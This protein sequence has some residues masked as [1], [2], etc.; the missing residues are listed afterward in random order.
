MENRQYTRIED[1]YPPRQQWFEVHIN[2]HQEGL[3]IYFG[4]ITRRKQ[5]ETELKESESRFHFFSSATTEGI[6]ILDNGKIADANISLAEMFGYSQD[7]IIGKSVLEFAPSEIHELI[8]EK[9]RSC[10]EGSFEL[11]GL[12]KDGTLFPLEAEGRSLEDRGR[13]VRVVILRNLEEKK[14]AEKGLKESEERFKFLSSVATEGV[15]IRSDDIII[16]AN[17][18]LANMFG[19]SLEELY[20]MPSRKLVTPESLEQ[21]QNQIKYAESS[22]SAGSPDNFVG[23]FEGVGIRKDGQTFPF[24]TRGRNMEYKGQPVRVTLL[25]DLRERKTA[26]EKLKES[27]ERFRILEEASFEGILVHDQGKIL[28]ANQRL[29]GM[30]GYSLSEIIDTPFLQLIAPES[31]PLVIRKIEEGFTGYYEAKGLRKDGTIFPFETQGRYIKYNGKQYRVKTIRDI[32]ERIQAQELLER[33]QA[34]LHQAQRME[35]IGQL[36]GGIAHDFNNLLTA[37]IGYG[38]LATLRLQPGDAVS[39]DIDEIL[40]AAMRAANLTHQ[41]LA[42][43][44]KQ[45]LQP[46]V[47]NLNNSVKDMD[48]LLQRLIGE[49][50]ELVS[51]LDPDLGLTLIDPGQFEQVI[52]NLAVNARDA[53]PKGGK[54]TI[55]TANIELDGNYQSQHGLKL[56]SGRYVMLAVSDNGTGMDEEIRSKIFDPFFTTKEVG[57]G[58]GLGLAT[59]Y[60]IVS[61]SGGYIFVYSE[62]GIGT[63]FKIYLPLYTSELEGKDKELLPM[64]RR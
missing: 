36:A 8:R 30:F 60:G 12:K 57:K 15:L 11:E 58:T 44:R 48:S 19:Y 31:R 17:K 26:E 54:L 22:F 49:D 28:D 56:V 14:A 3:S 62:I 10:S 40:K 43:S 6:V 18:A 64:A 25:R 34:Q 51:S 20:G 63:S 45:L 9:I 42:F 35:S 61:Q 23:P 33:T 32:T 46:K 16:D 53:M 37:I 5:Y 47:I 24:E 21:L 13:Q 1:F 50:I 38:E 29:G 59:V 2:P 4:D 7:E 52:L 41:L 39:N 55:E 27:E